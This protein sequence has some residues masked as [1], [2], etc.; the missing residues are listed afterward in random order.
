MYM[1]SLQAMSGTYVAAMEGHTSAWYVSEWLRVGG[2]NLSPA[3][4][5]VGTSYVKYAGGVLRATCEL[6]A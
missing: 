3:A 1:I 6:L 2:K 4:R 5:A